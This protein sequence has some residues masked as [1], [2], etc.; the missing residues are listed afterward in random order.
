MVI[1]LRRF[2][3]SKI[4]KFIAFSLTVVLITLTMVLSN[5]AINSRM[6]LESLFVKDYIKSD[7]FIYGK[8]SC[9]FMINNFINDT[10]SIGQDRIISIILLM[11]KTLSITQ[12]PNILK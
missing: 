11:E 9:Q 5:Y 6:N 7:S 8:L 12:V 1:K 4:T 3:R 10:E 2:S